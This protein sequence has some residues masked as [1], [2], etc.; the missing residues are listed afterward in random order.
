MK[1]TA[2]ASATALVS[3]AL[4]TSAATAS[5]TVETTDARAL[6]ASV[7][8][9]GPGVTGADTAIANQLHGQL[10]W[11]TAT[12][13][14]CARAVVNQVRAR[15]LTE[16]AA[17]IA[18]TTVITETHLNNYNV[19]LD[20]DSLG[21][22]QQRPSQGWGTPAQLVDP[23]YATNAFLNSMQS[24]YPNGSWG[25]GD[26]ADICQRV[27]RSAFP[28]GSNYR[29]NV[30]AASLV[31]DAVW[32]GT[33][34]HDFNGDGRADIVAWDPY[35]NLTLFPGDGAGHVSW[36][37]AMWPGAGE[38][39]GY[40]ELTAGDFNSDGRADIVAL[41]PYSNLT[42]FP[43]DGAGHVSWGGAMWPGAGEWTGY[44]ELTAGDFNGD[45]RTDIAA[46]DPY[47]NLTLFPG[48]GAGHVSWG[49]AMWPGAGEWTGYKELT[50]GDF[51][52]DGR[53]DV[54]AW[55][56]YSNLTFFPGDGAGHVSWGGAMW[57]GAGEWTGYKKLTA[58]DYN[59]DGRT[60]IAAIDPGSNL[61]LFP[62]DGAGH[63]GWGGGMWP[64]TGEWTGYKA[65]T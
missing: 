2:C 48:D 62:G 39:T 63:V 21:L 51:N 40:K 29:V 9:C 23:V 12:H 6:T 37:G 64:G 47:S 17:D 20:H 45:G 44:K 57:P 11:L 46:W 16:R 54:A 35:S 55:D 33:G 19:A 36:G 8:P 3:L 41:D 56:P 13:V 32:R 14:S 42:F 30:G 1:K 22:F 28:D 59:N 34:G 4:L 15:G 24:F 52:G 38:W 53:T 5:A 50:A 27:Q 7:A 26:I 31:V 60:D 65:I 10:T 49:G 43:G 58:A 25:S 61:I 18:I